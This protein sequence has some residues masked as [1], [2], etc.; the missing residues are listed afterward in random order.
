MNSWLA[1]TSLVLLRLLFDP[2]DRISGAFVRVGLG[3]PRGKQADQSVVNYAP[4]LQAILPDR[5]RQDAIAKPNKKNTEQQYQSERELR[6]HNV[7]PKHTA[8]LPI[9]P[10]HSSLFRARQR[11]LL[12]FQD[13]SRRLANTLIGRK[14]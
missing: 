13:F 4:R 14:D 6:A 5:R 9:H 12:D 1:Q 10:K 7:N 8:S 11:N 2:I 3:S